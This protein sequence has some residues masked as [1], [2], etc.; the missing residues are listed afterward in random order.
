MGLKLI[1]QK[2]LS[3]R[4][5]SMR[6]PFWSQKLTHLQIH[7]F[8]ICSQPKNHLQLPRSMSAE[9]G[10]SRVGA[11]LNHAGGNAGP[12]ASKLTSESKVFYF[13]LMSDIKRS[14]RFYAWRMSVASTVLHFCT[15]YF[16]S[17][18]SLYM[19][20]YTAGSAFPLPDLFCT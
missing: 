10:E 20:Y 2:S 3:Y 17:C 12:R 4:R 13:Y 14:H 6:A 8:P 19:L 7:Q 15:C 18:A 5:K 9:T 11:K 16:S 1:Q